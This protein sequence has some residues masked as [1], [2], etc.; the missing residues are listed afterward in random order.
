MKIKSWINAFRLRTLPLALSCVIVGSA[1]AYH[2]GVFN[3]MI[4]A[5]T[6][7]TTI[8]LQILSN[9]ANDLGDAQKG[10]DNDQRLGPTRAVQSGDISPKA[11]RNGVIFCA[12]L[13]LLSGIALLLYAFTID[14]KF[15]LW[16]IIGLGAI[17]AALKYT[18]G[19][20]AYGYRGL[21]DLFVFLFF[22]LVGVLGTS[23]MQTEAF[24]WIDLLPAS[25]I[26]LL[27][28]G[29]LNLNN[30]RDHKNDAA[31]GKFTIVTRMGISY[32]KFYH[33]L[34]CLIPFILLMVFLV[35]ERSLLA[36]I[37]LLPTCLL[38]GLSLRR[39]WRNQDE[40]ALDPELK[41]VAL[42]TFFTAILFSASLI[43]WF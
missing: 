43:F 39:V 14:W 37:S 36:F 29:V 23:Y 22:G 24:R 34:L 38:I 1:L 10:T 6:A 41:V 19:K 28:T 27:A 21:G 8:F 13:A 9:L 18:M 5:L 16:L 7:T 25:A 3:W 11:M 20:S 15:I 26:G 31:S 2:V 17:A 35:M 12:L 33:S 30:M 4:A 42:S 40:Q 32:A